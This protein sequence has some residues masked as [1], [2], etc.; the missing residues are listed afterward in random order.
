MGAKIPR[1]FVI[2]LALL[3]NA[4]A[5]DIPAISPAKTAAGAGMVSM[6]ALVPDIRLEMRYAGN[7]NFVGRP[8]RGYEAP[9][10]YLL[11]PVA[12]ALQRV[13]MRL[14]DQSMRLSIFDCYR[15]VR[16]VHN[17]VEWAHDLSD[18]KTKPRYYPRLDKKDLLG[19]YIAPT[20]GHSRGATLDLTLMQCDSQTHCGN[21][22]MGTDFDFFD[23]LAHTDSPDVT[24]L[25]HENRERLRAA[26]GKEGFQN[27]PMEWWHYTFQPEPSKDTAYD[28]PVK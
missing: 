1:F 26:M 27:Y 12:E 13:E 24:P 3:S 14:R 19:D 6:Q 20:S 28:F 5:E 21:L 18:Q 25:Q 17:F 10:C 22:D 16:S 7:N 15:P 4:G 9:H 8:V 2:A 23:V 11:R